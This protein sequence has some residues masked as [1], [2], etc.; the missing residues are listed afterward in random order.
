MLGI[1]TTQTRQKATCPCL[2]LSLA[3]FK[4]PWKGP[5]VEAC[6]RFW[7]A[8]YCQ[9]SLNTASANTP[10]DLQHWF[11]S[12][13]QSKR[14]YV[15]VLQHLGTHAEETPA[16]LTP[17]ACHLQA[18]S[19]SHRCKQHNFHLSL[20][21]LKG[22]IGAAV[23]I[24]PSERSCSCRCISIL[25]LL[26]N[27]HTT[28]I[29][30]KYTTKLHMTHP[31]SVCRSSGTPPPKAKLSTKPPG[32]MVWSSEINHPQLLRRHNSRLRIIYLYI[33]ITY[34]L[35]EMLTTTIAVSSQ[36]SSSSQNISN[37]VALVKPP[38]R[39]FLEG[40]HRLDCDSYVTGLSLEHSCAKT[41]ALNTEDSA[42]HLGRRVSPQSLATSAKKPHCLWWL[43]SLWALTKLQT[44][45]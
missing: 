35:I 17:K 25:L 19:N 27:R 24:Q 18:A 5:C 2:G 29:N 12:H 32:L 42:H 31:S 8:T 9:P 39:P 37:M 45:P 1:C 41:I 10:S 15:A 40:F 38:T 4:V 20:E 3:G 16:L 21:R 26:F 36:H 13:T 30:E 44:S 33:L 28:A 34:L 23:V 22:S 11:H 7:K 6:G 14:K 43:C